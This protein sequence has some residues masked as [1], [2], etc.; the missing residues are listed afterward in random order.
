MVICREFRAAESAKLMGTANRGTWDDRFFLTGGG[1]CQV[2]ALGVE[3]LARVR[4]EI[5]R[6]DGL[7]SAR[8]LHSLP[9]FWE[10]ET[11]LAVPHLG[12]GPQAIKAQFTVFD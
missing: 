1:S 8:I 5:G 9:A 11:L 7:P 2:R 3:G 12:Y 4:A 6:G 10:G